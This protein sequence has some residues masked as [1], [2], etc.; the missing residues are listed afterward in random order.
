MEGF[1]QYLISEQINDF[2]N[3]KA[4]SPKEAKREARDINDLYSKEARELYKN[5]ID[6]INSSKYS[7]TIDFIDDITSDKKL[8]FILSL[9]FGGRLA[10]MDL[11]I[12]EMPL[13]VKDLIPTQ[14][15]IGVDETFKCILEGKNIEYCFQ[16]PAVIKKPIVVFNSKYIIDGHHRWSE[17]Y[18]TNPNAKVEAVNITG[19]LSPIN[20]LK[21]FQCT[22]ASNLGKVIRTTK[23]GKNLL[24]LSK[25]EISKYCDEISQESRN[26]FSAYGIYDAEHYLLNNC[27]EMQ[28]NNKPITNAPP[29]TEMPQTSK[30][31]NLFFD[32]ENGV[33][34]IH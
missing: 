30:D 31:P 13:N 9:G 11:K 15:E 16:N 20:A 24:E 28:K 5:L 19:N 26:K 2:F 6:T 25:N 7:K 8:K 14:N 3:E 34:K 21:V 32:L 29:R 10:D 4:I 22:I 17:I 23:K 27:L 12:K 33:T 18:I 1:R